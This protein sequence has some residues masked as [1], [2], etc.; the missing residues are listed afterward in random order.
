MGTTQDMENPSERLTEMQ[1]PDIKDSRF[2]NK[3]KSLPTNALGLNEIVKW[4]VNKHK[5]QREDISHTS[6]TLK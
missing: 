5:S 6:E 2:E 3:V 4:V 1:N